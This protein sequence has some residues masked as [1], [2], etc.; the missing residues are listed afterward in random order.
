MTNSLDPDQTDPGPHCL[1]LHLNLSA[2]L[3]NYIYIRSRRDAFSRR[4]FFRWIYF[5][6][7]LRVNA[8]LES[9]SRI[10][11]VQRIVILRST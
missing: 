6:G 10:H 7:A 3:G 11:G 2:I 1:F 9:S 5:F 4:L 8:M